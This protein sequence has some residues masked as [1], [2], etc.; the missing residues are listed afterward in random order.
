MSYANIKVKQS[1]AMDDVESGKTLSI[2]LGFH[3]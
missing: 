2:H 1:E 3:V